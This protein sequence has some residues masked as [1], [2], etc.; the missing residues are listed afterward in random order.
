MAIPLSQL[1]PSFWGGGEG[2]GRRDARAILNGTA[3]LCPSSVLLRHDGPRHS[4]GG[5]I[6][7]YESESRYNNNL[8]YGGHAGYG[9]YRNDEQ[10]SQRRR[11]QSQ[12]EAQRQG[13][14]EGNVE[15]VTATDEGQY[16]LAWSLRGV[17]THGIPCAVAYIASPGETVIDAVGVDEPYMLALVDNVLHAIVYDEIVEPRTFYMDQ[18][19]YS[20]H[21]RHQQGHLG[22]ANHHGA[23]NVNV[24][25][26][27]EAELAMME[28]NGEA[29]RC[30]ERRKP[31]AHFSFLRNRKFMMSQISA[32]E[33]VLDSQ[34][35]HL[36]I[37]FRTT[38]DVL[39]GESEGD[40]EEGSHARP[41]GFDWEPG[42]RL[43][44]RNPLDL[45]R[46]IRQ[47]G[48]AI[49]V[50]AGL[51]DL[52]PPTRPPLEQPGQPSPAPTP[53]PAPAPVSTPVPAPAPPSAVETQ[54]P[55]PLQ[56]SPLIPAGPI[57]EPS[58]DSPASHSKPDLESGSDLSGSESSSASDSNS[59][60]SIDSDS[61]SDDSL[62][63]DE[64]LKTISRAK[65]LRD[66]A[67]KV[68]SGGHRH[69]HH[70][71][72]H[73]DHHHDHHDHHD[74]HEHR[75]HHLRRM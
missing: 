49:R 66:S 57:T 46:T 25:S 30:F 75:H 68:A 16:H 65:L 1:P 71:H 13:A 52:E 21:G 31:P 56:A 47:W 63:H 18:H 36:G 40:G 24:A 12:V 3:E 48:Y 74:Y 11:S 53:T 41:S 4:S 64:I 39:E 59:E 50:A 70:H 42:L 27:V 35:P 58:S 26:V 15:M 67:K 5:P 72:D 7:P 69:H 22:S 38:H 23:D 73:H 44:F 43:H 14:G 60:S 32:V 10:P 34:E 45:G 54:P 61:D 6:A 28:S 19:P 29:M 17:P 9:G 55:P 37:T 62:A 20:S 2:E 33:E 8:E 51:I